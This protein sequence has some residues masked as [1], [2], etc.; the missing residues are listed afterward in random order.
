MMQ[1]TLIKRGKW[2]IVDILAKHSCGNCGEEYAARVDKRDDAREFNMPHPI[3][4][5]NCGVIMDT[6]VMVE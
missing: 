1:S 6:V 4:C 2:V 3:T 5:R